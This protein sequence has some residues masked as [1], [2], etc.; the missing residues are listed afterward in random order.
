MIDFMAGSGVA[1]GVATDR[2]VPKSGNFVRRV[3]VARVLTDPAITAGSA[4]T[5]SASSTRAMTGLKE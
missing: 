4:S 5:M 2:V 3:R 1:T